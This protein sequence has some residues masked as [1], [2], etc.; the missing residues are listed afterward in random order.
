M[1]DFEKCLKKCVNKKNCVICSDRGRMYVCKCGAMICTLTYSSAEKIG[2]MTMHKMLCK[3]IIN[4][5]CV[6]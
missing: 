1:Y 2:P 4:E 5:P 6:K 3:R